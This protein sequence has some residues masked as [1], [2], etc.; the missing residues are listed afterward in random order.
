V[1]TNI[2]I[3]PAPCFHIPFQERERE[4]AVFFFTG[5]YFSQFQ[6]ADNDLDLNAVEYMVLCSGG[7][8]DSSSSLEAAR[9]QL[10]LVF[11]P[12]LRLV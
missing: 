1:R 5:R 6:I 4:R 10:G 8:P 3:H 9:A 12:A 11:A 2:K 7:S